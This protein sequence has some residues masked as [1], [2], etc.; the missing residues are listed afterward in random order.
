MDFETFTKIEI[1]IPCGCY[2]IFKFDTIY[3]DD[4]HNEHSS[5]GYGMD[6]TFIVKE[7]EK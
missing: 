6:R 2:E 4:L 3:D 1:S 7:Y 5:Y